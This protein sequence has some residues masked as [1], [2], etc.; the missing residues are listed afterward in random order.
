M[1]KI[2][3]EFEEEMQTE[4]VLQ[5]SVDVSFASN[6]FPKYKLG[7]DNQILEEPKE[8]NH[9]PSL[10]EVVEQETVS[11][12]EQHKRLS[13]RDLASKFDKNLSAAAKLSDEAKLREVA[14]LEGHV[15]LKKLR[16]ALESLRGRLAGRNKEDVEKAISM[17]EA[18]AVKLTQKEGELIQEKFE[19]KKLASYLK[20]ASEDA[21]KLVNQEKSFACAEIESARSVVQ[22]IGEALEE[23]ERN[24]QASKKQDV[25]ELIEEVQEARRIKLLHQPSKVVDMEYELRALR[26][27]IWEK[28][29]FSVKLQK[30]LAIRKRDE[31]NK[32]RL[33]VLEGSE[34]LGSYLKLKPCSDKAPQLPN[35]SIQWYRL[36]SEGTWKEIISGANKSIYAPEPFDVGRILQAEIVSNG[37]KLTVTTSGP[38]DPAAGLGSYVETL[39]RKSNTEFNVVISQMNGQDH[40]SHSVHVFHVGKMR[41]KL[42][43]GWITKA[44]ENYSSSMQLC[45]GRGDINNSAK[46]LFW[47]ARKGLSYVLTFES[48][49]DR[50]AA[51]MLARKYAF[52]CN[53][54]LAGPDDQV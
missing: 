16:D 46:A 48:E 10:K 54:M 43:R 19:V 22:R 3:P 5:V 44:R 2:S 9:G 35:C 20:Q 31:E 17:V 28:S 39:L 52:D 24:S 6:H 4:E 26:A 32:F 1:T 13:V 33:Y 11:L 25:E 37:Q 49:R 7:A 38:I 23:Q 21:K 50:N 30:E 18:L 45:G 27:Q 12:S 8:D 51:V 40:A 41:I 15:L 36:S 42:S 34:N 14:S 29:V 53:V 47:Q